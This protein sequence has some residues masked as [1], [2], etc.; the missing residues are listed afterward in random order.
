M[1]KRYPK[2]GKHRRYS[3]INEYRLVGV[4]EAGRG[5]VLGPMVIAICALT[6]R[7]LRWCNRHGVTDS[8]AIPSNRRDD[9]AKALR[10]RCWHQI[11]V[12]NPPEIDEAVHNRSMTLNGLEIK[13]MSGLIRLFHEAF[14]Q[15]DAEI[16][17]DAPTRKTPPFRRM[18]SHLS[19]W[20]NYTKLKPE[21]FADQN[22]RHLGAASIRAKTERDRLMREL[23]ISLNYNLGSGYAHDKHSCDY[24][25]QA[26]KDDP[27]VRW[28]WMTAS[29]LTRDKND[30]PQALF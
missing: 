30:K 28:S 2:N 4:D 16:M 22:H 7:D 23:S 20:E 17:L 8:K 3:D 10:E 21:N 5:P 24:V 25:A 9:L 26:K 13:Y 18:I 12:I 14:P 19:V 27:I 11:A 29:Q 1:A 6:R 15:T